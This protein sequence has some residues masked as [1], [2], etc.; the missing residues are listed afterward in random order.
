MPRYKTPKA[1]RSPFQDMKGRD[2][3]LSAGLSS[4]FKARR[5]AKEGL[6]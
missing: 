5:N 6:K 4:H 3:T 1:I 2:V